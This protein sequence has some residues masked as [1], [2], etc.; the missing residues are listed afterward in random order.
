M[1]VWELCIIEHV[2]LAGKLPFSGLLG[3]AGAYQVDYEGTK[4]GIPRII[5]EGPSY[6][7]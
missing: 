6:G 1:F 7:V 4:G 3:K 2:L 5:F